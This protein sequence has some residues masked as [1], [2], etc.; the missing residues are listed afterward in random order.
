[1]INRMVISSPVGPLTIEEQDGAITHLLFGLC[2]ETGERTPVLKA[3]EHQLA[4]Y[5]EGKRRKFDLPLN[6]SGTEFQKKVWAALGEIPYGETRSY[7]DI[8]RAV[9]REKAFRAVGMANHNNPISII[10]P[11]HRVIGAD[12]S[13][14]GYGGGLEIKR[15]LLRLEGS[16]QI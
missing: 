13:M 3:A 16:V 9:G 4:E 8:A 5:F 11:C 12:G 15:F 2:D 1:M 10:I 14:T 6:P 7:G